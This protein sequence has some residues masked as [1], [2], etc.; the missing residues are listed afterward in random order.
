MLEK[1]EVFL[2]EVSELILHHCTKTLKFLEQEDWSS[3]C[4]SVIKNTTQEL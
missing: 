3:H 2:E 1:K 4:E